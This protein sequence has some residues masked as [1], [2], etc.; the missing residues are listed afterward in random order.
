MLIITTTMIETP[1][2][3]P[4][5]TLP[6]ETAGSNATIVTTVMI[7]IEIMRMIRM[8]VATLMLIPCCTLPCKTAARNDYSVVYHIIP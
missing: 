3:I 5:C 8:T 7:A 2:L 4:R 6:C 1:M